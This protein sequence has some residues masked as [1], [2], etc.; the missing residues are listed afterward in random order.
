MA[1]HALTQH[2]A[3]F[4]KK[5]NPSPSFEATAASEHKTIRGL[6]ENPNGPA[7]SLLPTCFLQGSYKQDTAIYTINDVDLVVLCRL[8]QGGE[9]TGGGRSYTRNEIFQIIAAPLVDDYRYR[10]KVVY[11][12]TSMCIKVN[13]GIKV[14]ILP[15]VYKS[16]I[17]DPQAEPFRLYRRATG[18]WE[19]GYAQYQQKQLSEAN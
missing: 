10:G 16:G 1:N 19:D 12:P 11:G 6:I 5:L 7:A 3:S 8:W 4:F 13:L 9:G 2:F 15:V 17:Y 18:L 14:E